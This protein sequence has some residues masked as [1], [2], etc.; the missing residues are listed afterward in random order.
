MEAIKK[1]STIATW[2]HT[3]KAAHENKNTSKQISP[4]KKFSENPGTAMT[5]RL[6]VWKDHIN[7]MKTKYTHYLAQWIKVTE[8]KVFH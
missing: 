5:T 7:P 1:K 3:W 2:P 8:V 4:S 6:Q